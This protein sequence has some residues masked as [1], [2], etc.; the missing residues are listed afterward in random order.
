M[1]TTIKSRSNCTKTATRDEPFAAMRPVCHGRCCLQSIPPRLRQCFW[2][3]GKCSRGTS[4][5]L[6]PFE[7]VQKPNEFTAPESP[8]AGWFQLKLRPSTAWRG[9]PI[10]ETARMGTKDGPVVYAQIANRLS[11]LIDDVAKIEIECDE[12]RE[13]LSLLVTNKERTTLPARGLS[14]M[15]LCGSWPWLSWRRI[16]KRKESSVWKNREN[17]MH[18]DRIPAILQLLKDIA[19]DT[20]EPVGLDNPLRQIIVN[21]HSPSVVSQVLDDDLL[22]GRVSGLHAGHQTF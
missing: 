17:G 19:V 20:E 18:P 2:H 4:L 12:K 21:T 9:R 10:R 1:L 13:L 3:V 15:A 22:C 11:E 5:Q 6:E 16:P 8:W 14:P 7:L